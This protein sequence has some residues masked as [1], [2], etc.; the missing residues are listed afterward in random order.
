MTSLTLHYRLYYML[1][2]EYW[3]PSSHEQVNRTIRRLD[4][5]VQFRL[6]NRYPR[7]RDIF[8]SSLQYH[9]V[10]WCTSSVTE[11]KPFNLACSTLW[12]ISTAIPKYGVIWE[13]CCGIIPRKCELQF[14][15]T[16]CDPWLTLTFFF[17]QNYTTL[18]IIRHWESDPLCEETCSIC[19]VCLVRQTWQGWEIEGPLPQASELPHRKLYDKCHSQKKCLSAHSSLLPHRSLRTNY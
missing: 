19:T 9:G 16:S 3:P 2:L 14:N 15:T 6:F 7:I 12:C 4:R 13:P 17:T 11:E 8:P 18:I 1:S 5:P 10:Q